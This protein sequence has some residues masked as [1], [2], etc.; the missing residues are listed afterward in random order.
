M[1]ER[2]GGILISA[3]GAQ[4]FVRRSEQSAFIGPALPNCW[5]SDKQE[6][7]CISLMLRQKNPASR[8]PLSSP[9]P[10]AEFPDAALPPAFV[11]V[12]TVFSHT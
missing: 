9:P 3:S 1:C 7:I 12:Q 10:P 8:H 11:E 5:P 6:L 2:D 4:S